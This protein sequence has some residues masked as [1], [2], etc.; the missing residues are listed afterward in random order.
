MIA[1]IRAVKRVG[2]T[3]I[4]KRPA[5]KLSRGAVATR[6][7]DSG[8]GLQARYGAALATPSSRAKLRHLIGIE[9]WGLRRLETL[10]GKEPLT[11]EYDGYQPSPSAS[12][13]DLKL[14]FA[15]TRRTLVALARQ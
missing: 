2:R 14:A 1:V 8:K 13:R 15:N 11:D 9:R 12:W 6:W 7:E 4:I 10:A 5:A 3:R